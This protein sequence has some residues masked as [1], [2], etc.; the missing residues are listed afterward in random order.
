MLQN[1]NVEKGIDNTA[2]KYCIDSGVLSVSYYCLLLRL[3][4]CS[5]TN[6][7]I[8]LLNFTFTEVFP[9]MRRYLHF[10]HLTRL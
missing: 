10:I 3:E 9:V 2:F 5:L 1:V 7:G 6:G 4:L 8:H